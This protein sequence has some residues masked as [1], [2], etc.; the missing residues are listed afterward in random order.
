MN[1]A[2]HSDPKDHMGYSDI[3]NKMNITHLYVSDFLKDANRKIDHLI[4]DGNV[5]TN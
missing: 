1:F 5:H 2:Y 3:P 4:V